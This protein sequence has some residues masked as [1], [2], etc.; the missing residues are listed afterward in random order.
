MPQQTAPTPHPADTVGR[1]RRNTHIRLIPRQPGCAPPD[2]CRTIWSVFADIK[3]RRVAH[4]APDAE[5]VLRMTH[6]R[7]R[8]S[9]SGQRVR[10][11]FGMLIMVAVLFLAVGIALSLALGI[12]AES[13]NSFAIV[14]RQPIIHSADPIMLS[15]EG[16]PP[17][18]SNANPLPADAKIRAIVVSP[19]EVTLLAGGVKIRAVRLKTAANN[20]VQVVRA[21]NNTTWLGLSPHHT[22]TLAAALVVD[23]GHFTVGSRAIKV[24]QLMDLPGVFIGVRQGILDFD[25]VLV[26]PYGAKLSP[27]SHFRPFVVAV[28]KSTMNTDD[29]TFSHLGWNW[30]ASYGVSWVLGATGHALGSTFAYSYIGAYSDRA[31]GLV[32]HAD[33]FRNNSLYGLDPHTYSVRLVVS[34]IL[35]E[36]NKAHGIIFANHVTHSTISHS[37]SRDNGENGIMMYEGSSDNTIVDNVVSGNTGDGLVAVGSPLNIFARNL[38]TYNRIGVRVKDSGSEHITF[39][40]NRIVRNGLTS[41]GIQLGSSN[42][43]LNNGGQADWPILRSIWLA[44]GLAWLLF[45]C[46]LALKSASNNRR[47]ALAATSLG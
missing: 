38:A 33:T 28:G 14:A 43:A 41:E 4:F 26:R 12:H 10:R 24:V 9:R 31:V 39:E 5:D 40:G 45:A 18:S 44:L 8:H 34:D 6:S 27:D 20:L 17:N 25:H 46:L 36:Y 7:H 35:A 16:E 11:Y 47:N 22:I 3:Q 42:I 2:G 13:Y 30:D 37:I 15:L 19:H 1:R 32:F 21:I 23:G 29:S